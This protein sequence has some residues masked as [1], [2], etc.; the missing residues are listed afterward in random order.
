VVTR[1]LAQP[2]PNA[3][4]SKATPTIVVLA[5]VLFSAVF[6]VLAWGALHDRASAESGPV[7]ATPTLPIAPG[8]GEG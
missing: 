2:S 6:L 1:D 5:G 7:L 8:A 3:I 4:R